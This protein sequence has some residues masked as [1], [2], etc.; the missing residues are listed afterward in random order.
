MIAKL[1][2]VLTSQKNSAARTTMIA[3]IT[4]VIQVSL[5]LVQVILRASARTSRKNFGAP[6]TNWIRFG[7]LATTAVAEGFAMTVAVLAARSRIACGDF[8]GFLAM[9]RFKLSSG[10]AGSPRSGLTSS[11]YRVAGVEGLE[12]PALGFGDRCSTS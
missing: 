9:R 5:R 1:R 11:L 10:A 4:E 2:A 3:T 8:P 7:P 6:M 12:P